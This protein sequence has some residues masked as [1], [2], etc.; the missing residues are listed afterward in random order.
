MELTDIKALVLS[1]DQ[2]AQ[3]Y[4]SARDGG[5]FTRWQET[6]RISYTADDRHVRGWHFVIDRFAKKEFDPVAAAIEQVLTDSPGVAYAYSVDYESDTGYIHHIF[7][8]EGM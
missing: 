4:E 1:A 5:A 2:Q 6:R 8:C 7:D 3:H